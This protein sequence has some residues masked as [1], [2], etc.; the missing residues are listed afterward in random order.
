MLLLAFLRE[1]ENR[2]VN[3]MVIPWLLTGWLEPR[4]R[5]CIA[6]WSLHRSCLRYIAKQQPHLDSEQQD[7]WFIF[8]VKF[9]CKTSMLCSACRAVLFSVICATAGSRVDDSDLCYRGRRVEVHG[10]CCQRYYVNIFSAARN[11]VD[12]RDSCCSRLLFHGSF[13]YSGINDCRLI[14][15]NERH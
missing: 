9:P 7:I 11:H 15:E 3:T 12:V 4:A 1:G 2:V 13:F 8:S 6:S 14:S 5:Q 10:L